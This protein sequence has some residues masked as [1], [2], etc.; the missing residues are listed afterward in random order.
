[1]SDTENC[2]WCALL[3]LTT[4]LDNASNCPRCVEMSDDRLLEEFAERVESLQTKL[5][6]ANK[7]NAPLIEALDKMNGLAINALAQAG[8][9]WDQ[10]SDMVNDSCELAEKAGGPARVVEPDTEALANAKGATDEKV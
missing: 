4:E 3:N 6:E 9:S 2:V 5:D 7:V 10:I 8:F 1:M